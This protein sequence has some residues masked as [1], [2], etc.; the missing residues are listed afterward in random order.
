M[1]REGPQEWPEDGWDGP[2]EQ[3]GSPEGVLGP[4]GQ[5]GPPEGLEGP[6]DREGPPEWSGGK[7]GWMIRR[8]VVASIPPLLL[9][10]IR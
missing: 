3:E 6:M 10:S 1:E 8:S 2:M 5:E 9:A 4:F 7:I